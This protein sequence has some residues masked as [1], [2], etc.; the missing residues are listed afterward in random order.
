MADADYDYLIKFLALGKMQ[1]ATCSLAHYFSLGIL[2]TVTNSVVMVSKL[3]LLAG[4]GGFYKEIVNTV[5]FLF[6]DECASVLSIEGCWICDM[7]R[8]I[9]VHLKADKMASLI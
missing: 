1:N 2:S 3:L 4:L 8:Y 9:N 7:I 5:L 6:F